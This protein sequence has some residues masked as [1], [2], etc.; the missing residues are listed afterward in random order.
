MSE[1]ALPSSFR[2]PSG[3]VFY[4]D[5]VLYR[6]INQSYKENYEKLISSGLYKSLA[7]KCFIVPHEEISSDGGITI[8][9]LQIPFISYPYE[10]C[11]SQLK[12]AALLTLDI[13]KEALKFGMTLKDCSAYNIQFYKG[14]AIFIDTLS[15]ETYNEGQPWI[16]YKQ[17]CQHFLAPLALIVYKDIRLNNLSKEFLDGIPLDLASK[18][19]PAETWFK[20]SLLSHIHIHSKSQK[21]YS[22]EE[23]KKSSFHISKQSLLALID[24]LE[25]AVKK[26][27]WSP[28]KTE[29][30]DYYSD[31]SYTDSVMKQKQ[32]TVS[33][34]IDKVNPKNVWDLGGNTGRFS[35]IA[36]DKGL[37]TISFDI[38]PCAIESSYQEAKKKGEKNILPLVMDLTNASPGIGWANNERMPLIQRGPV[39][40]ALA[41][42]LV[43][44]LAISNNVPFKK[45]ADFLGSVCRAL[46]IEF[47]P[48]MDV[49]VQRLLSSREDVFPGYTRENFEQEFSK[50]FAIEKSLNIDDSKRVLYLMKNKKVI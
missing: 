39:D 32:K 2:D 19:L 36:S 50:C 31:N 35:R 46:I 37:N 28:G 16:A 17:F 10:W 43:H 38:D 21:R 7:G 3:Y 42:A 34:F 4:K 49:Q 18:I 6:R 1:E 30:A 9:P 15:F 13:Q 26:L 23:I 8:K 14:K 40:L 41:L 25:T 45:I 11:F 27:R 24:N 22:C 5:S 12:D 47:V 33:E 29:W 20:L 48:K 44:H